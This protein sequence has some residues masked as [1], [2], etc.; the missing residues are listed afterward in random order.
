MYR[1]LNPKYSRRHPNEAF[2]YDLD[3]SL[4]ETGIIETYTQ[5]GTI[6]GPTLTPKP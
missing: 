6:K 4:T 1:I 3:G 2:F 5:G